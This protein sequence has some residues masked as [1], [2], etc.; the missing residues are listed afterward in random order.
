MNV[1][2]SEYRGYTML[3][4]GLGWLIAPAPSVRS[5]RMRASSFPVGSAEPVEA[6]IAGG[7]NG[8]AREELG[9]R[10]VDFH[11]QGPAGGQRIAP[12]WAPHLDGQVPVRAGGQGAEQIH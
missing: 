9:R 7:R 10:S 2:I 6:P 1:A 12:L 11:G 3:S 8:P 4:T 5:V